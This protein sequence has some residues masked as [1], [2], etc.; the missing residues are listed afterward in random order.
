MQDESHGLKSHQQPIG[1]LAHAKNL[2]KF[3]PGRLSIYRQST[4]VS[5]TVL[6]AAGNVNTPGRQAARLC[7][8]LWLKL[9]DAKDITAMAGSFNGPK[10]CAN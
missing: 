2:K 9:V 5:A 7:L 1:L 8:R 10:L 4:S 6:K 3:V